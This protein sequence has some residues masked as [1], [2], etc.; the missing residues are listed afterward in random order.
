MRSRKILGDKGL[1][2]GIH[3]LRATIE[4]HGELCMGDDI[5]QAS[6]LVNGLSSKHICIYPKVFF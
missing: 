3:Y 6:I 1:R 4:G 2:V 5:S